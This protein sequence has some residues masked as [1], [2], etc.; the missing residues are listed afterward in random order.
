MKKLL[1]LIPL[2]GLA[3]GTASADP[4]YSA[5][6][7][8]GELTPYD[9]QPV[10]S[11]EALYN[12]S[13]KSQAPDT[14]G[15]RLN[16]SLYSDGE[17]AVRHQF[18]VSAAY[19]RGT[20][21]VSLFGSDDLFKVTAERMPLTLGYDVNIALFENVMLD[22]GV[23]GGYAFGTAELNA[24]GVKEHMGGATYSMGAGIKVQLS[25]SVS[26]KLGYEFSRTFY[27]KF[28]SSHLNLNQHG[29]V[30]GVGVLF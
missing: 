13:E 23:K 20:D 3:A 8:G 22:L 27:R 25:E 29:I 21:K 30:L 2:L 18:S 28:G 16:F 14:S 10:Y 26:G 9:L 11:L 17:S 6:P 24:F 7:A 19:E 15:A 5:Q 12:F 4:Y 1:S